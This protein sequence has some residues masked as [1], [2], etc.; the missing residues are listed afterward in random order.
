MLDHDHDKIC[1]TKH[2]HFRALITFERKFTYIFLLRGVSSIF[3]VSFSNLWPL[4]TEISAKTKYAANLMRIWSL[5]APNSVIEC[6]KGRVPAKYE[7][8]STECKR[9]EMRW[10]WCS[11]SP[12]LRL[13]WDQS[14]R[15][16][17]RFSPLGSYAKKWL[18]KRK[19][20]PEEGLGTVPC[21]KQA[22]FDLAPKNYTQ[23]LH[24]P[25][26]SIIFC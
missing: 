3:S 14:L 11:S 6:G 16:F 18:N 8:N 12:L 25:D 20:W 17:R 10:Q 9:S 15:L 26:I 23:I 1:P 22:L 13:H 4:S 2:H 19:E 24:T 7:L 5:P 21:P